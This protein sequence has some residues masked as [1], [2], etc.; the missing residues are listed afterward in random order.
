M[1][2]SAINLSNQARDV[3]CVLIITEKHKTFMIAI[4][5]VGINA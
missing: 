4:A 5:D 1:T 2:T 3:I